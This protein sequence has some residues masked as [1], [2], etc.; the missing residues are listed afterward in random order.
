MGKLFSGLASS[1]AADK[2]SRPNGQ[3]TKR[4]LLVACG[5]GH[6]LELLALEQAWRDLDHRFV[7]Q[8][9]VDATHLLADEDVVYGYGPSTRSISCLLRNL[10]LAWT[11]IRQYRPD[12]IL[13]TGAHIEVPFF[14]VG[15]LHRLRLIHVESLT[16]LERP[17][18]SGRMVYP[19]ADAFFVQ[20]PT[21]APRRRALYAG[22]IM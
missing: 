15:R 8:R 3:T 12:V 22:S 20:W 7:T 19:L 2:S 1:L 18:L 16:R 5:G 17:S 11:T 13:S 21:S 6:L 14:I 9:T 4:I 10:R